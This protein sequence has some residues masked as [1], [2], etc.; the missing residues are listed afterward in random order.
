MRFFKFSILLFAVAVAAFASEGV[1]AIIKMQQNGVSQ[2][3]L[4]AYVQNSTT[5]YDPSAEE[6]VQL[7]DAGVPPQVILAM[8]ERGKELSTAASGSNVLATNPSVT[9][10]SADDGVVAP[11][12]DDQNVSF[13]YEAL[14]PYG[15]WVSTQDYGWCWHPTGVSIETDWRPYANGGHWVWTDSGWYWE[16]SYPWG[17]A[18]FHYGR[19]SYDDRYHWVWSPDTT[20]GPAW[21][22][23]RASDDFYGWAPLP[24]GVAFEAG[25]GFSFHNRH[26]GFDFD[27]GLTDRDFAFVP[28]AAFLEVD[29]GRRIVPRAEAT[30]VFRQTSVVKN[31]YVAQDHRVFDSGIP[32]DRVAA[33]TGKQLE[34]VRIADA[35]I[36]AGK[37]VK[38][39]VRTGNTLAVFRPKLANTAPVDPPT[40]MQ[41]LRERTAERAEQSVRER[42]QPRANVSTMSEADARKRLQDEIKT[43][44]NQS[45][46]AD[47]DAAQRKADEE[48]RRAEGERKD[49]KETTPEKVK[50]QERPTDQ[51]SVQQREAEQKRLQQ[52]RETEQRQQLQERQNEPRN[53]QVRESEQRNQ[54]QERQTEQ[55]N[56]QQQR[57]AEQQQQL[58]ERQNTQRN[59][60]QERATEQRQ[61][62]QERV[63]P[64]ARVE[65][66]KDER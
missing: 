54:L 8:I 61:T 21:V 33:R 56:L 24:Y 31:S 65:P 17:W 55:R 35:N 2:P 1:D 50:E 47:R 6:I 52:Q 7:Q 62:E 14:A 46:N 63:Q 25:V 18:P 12:P 13:F 28:A 3:V 38:G 10:V 11:A 19:W 53:P 58:Q 60:Q 59:Q 64:P 22:T 42:T 41:R 23:W 29:I 27:F 66:K 34:Q 36:A 43:R 51:R 39:E 4:M 16:S 48:K 32:S 26:V 37:P 45:L 44:R 5:M 9:D 49:F 40:V 57:A 20:W 15:E 30:T